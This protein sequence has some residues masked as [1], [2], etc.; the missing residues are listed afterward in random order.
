M[1]F[2]IDCNLVTI[3]ACPVFIFSWCVFFL[4]FFSFFCLWEQSAALRPRK[5]HIDNKGSEHGNH[6]F[7]G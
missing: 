5:K 3:L 7:Y 2:C 4:V 6:G 1:N